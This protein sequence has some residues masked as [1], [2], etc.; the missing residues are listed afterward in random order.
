[1]LVR[2]RN[3]CNAPIFPVR[4]PHSKDY[5]LVHDLRAI[6]AIVDTEV[7]VVPDPHTLLSNIPPE[8]RWYTVIDLCPAFFWCTSR[9]TVLVC[10]QVRGTTRHIHKTPPG[11]L[12]KSHIVQ[13]RIDA[14]GQRAG[15][16]RASGQLGSGMVGSGSAGSRRSLRLGDKLPS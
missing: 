1:M 15:G 4:K 12:R 9:L 14:V 3:P 11:L 16:E 10:I 2:T 7:P 5:R 6:N 13:P 8:A